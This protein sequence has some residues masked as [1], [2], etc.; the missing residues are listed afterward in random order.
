MKILTKGMGSIFAVI[1]SAGVKTIALP[2]SFCPFLLSPLP[3]LLF[4]W[5]GGSRAPA[6]RL[7]GPASPSTPALGEA[8]RPECTLRRLGGARTQGSI[9]KA[10]LI[11][12]FCPRAEGVFSKCHL[13]WVQQRCQGL[14]LEDGKSTR[15]SVSQTQSSGLCGVCTFC[16]TQSN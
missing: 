4:Q 12:N 9:L 15:H 7:R 8:A 16:H 11:S 2:G 14:W 10:Q 1:H 6:H 13:L 3:L 5:E